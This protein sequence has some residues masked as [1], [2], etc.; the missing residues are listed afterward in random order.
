MTESKTNIEYKTA[1][2][3]FDVQKDG[4][5]EL[6]EL[7]DL[8]KSFGIEVSNEEKENLFYESCSKDANTLER[9]MRFTEYVNM[10]N[11]RS[12][13]MDTFDEYLEAF[14][15]FAEDD[16]RI[17]IET[18]DQVLRNLGENIS[19]EEIDNFLLEANVKGDGYIEYKEFIRLM[20][21]KDLEL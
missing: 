7:A 8:L 16:E 3:I 14:R 1:F 18:V 20:L 12:K 6:D 19:S 15:V 2:D 13:E 5:I 21:C 10:M 11:K 17:S 9:K 4:V